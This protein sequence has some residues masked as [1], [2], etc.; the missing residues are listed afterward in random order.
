MAKIKRLL[1]APAVLRQLRS[2]WRGYISWHFLAE[3]P[4]IPAKKNTPEEPN[5][6]KAFF[7][8][9]VT[10]PGIWKWKHY[11]DIYH[12]HL[13]R[14][15]GREINIL[16]IGVYSG[17]SLDMWSNYFGDK[18]EIYGVDIEPAC[19]AYE[20]ERIKILIG[21]QSSREFWGQVKRDVPPLDVIIDDGS[22]IPEMQIV[23]MEELL[24]HLNRGGVFICEDIHGT[25]NPYA[26]YAAGWS[27]NLHACEDGADN[28]QDNERRIVFKTTPFQSEFR[29]VHFYPF[30]TVIE[31]TAAPVEELICPK[32]GTE[33]QPFLK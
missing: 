31:K 24:P 23:T 10:G 15:R 4:S 22:H 32:H 14:F 6:L 11:F 21:D 26:G 19:K 3:Q 28:L 27:Q 30:V 13:N 25:L 7:D 2:F 12:H 16:E 20:K 8:S 29:S 1:R 17:G 18:C 33:W 9:H 5:P